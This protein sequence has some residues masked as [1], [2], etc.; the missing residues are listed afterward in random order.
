MGYRTDAEV[1]KTRQGRPGNGIPAGVL[2]Q[3]SDFDFDKEVAEAKKVANLMRGRWELP[4]S[5]TWGHINPR[6]VS[7]ESLERDLPA[8]ERLGRADY[9]GPTDVLIFAFRRGYQ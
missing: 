4:G 3:N 9:M 6:N 1:Y 5:H 8:V 7:M 2:D